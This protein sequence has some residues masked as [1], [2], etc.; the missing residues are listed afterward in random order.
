MDKLSEVKLV[1]TELLLVPFESYA[2]K[3]PDGSCIAYPDPGPTGLPI[4][5]GWGSTFDDT[6]KPVEVGEIWSYEKALRVKKNILNQYLITLLKMSPSLA[7]EPVERIAAVLSWCYNCGFGNYRISTFKKKIDSKDW[8]AASHEC[9][10][11]NKAKGKV[12]NGL[13][14][15]RQAE[16]TLILKPKT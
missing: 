15:R 12:L 16:A 11:W 8:L 3:L 14:K 7:T 9:L 10:L 13:T 5:I 4:T 6:G 2:K 1:C